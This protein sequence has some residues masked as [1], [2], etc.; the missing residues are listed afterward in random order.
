MI[1]CLLQN[2]TVFALI[3]GLNRKGANKTISQGAATNVY[4]TLA[5]TSS[6]SPGE[7]Y[8]NCRVERVE[9]HPNI[10]DEILGTKLWDT[11]IK[12]LQSTEW[13]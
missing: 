5:P 4:C 7:F 10:H 3:E 12:G 9:V 13:I 2:G 1:S 11:S 8:T 6:L